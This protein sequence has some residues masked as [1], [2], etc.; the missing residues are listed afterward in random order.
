MMFGGDD[1]TPSS[2]TYYGDTWTWHGPPDPT[3]P[4]IAL[5]VGG[6]LGAN[7]WYVSDVSVGWDVQ[8]LESPILSQT[9]CNATVV[10]ADTA[11]TAFACTA[12][13]NG[14]TS[15]ESVTIKKDTTSPSI[16]IGS[17]LAFAVEPLALTLNFSAA[18]ALSGIAFLEA[19]L[20]DG[21][22]P[23]S[24][25]TGEQVFSPGLYTLT[26]TATDN[27]GNN[28]TEVRNFVVYDPSA[29]FASG[30][31]W[32]VPGKEGK[33]DPDDILPGL[34]GTSKALLGFVVKYQQG[35]STAP[36][37]QLQFRYRAGDFKLDS[38]GYKWLVVTNTNW[39]KFQGNA[40]INGSGELHPFRVDAR[41]GDARGGN[42]P[43]RFV[44]KVWAPGANPDLDSPIYKA[45]GDLEGGQINIHK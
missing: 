11:G 1:C 36:E 7:G 32:I 12:T 30:G 23:V 16:T 45:S 6:T 19:V 21:T 33:S 8:D 10:V 41:D 35:A 44:I 31:G 3:P 17:P 9:G 2:C 40:T 20:D 34:D 22:G 29:G 15:A 24:V 5:S 25:T 38:A 43:D 28:S 13:S 26:V 14:G 42:F 18:D 27:A 4:A 37:G 39:A